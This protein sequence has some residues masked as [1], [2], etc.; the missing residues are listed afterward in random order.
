MKQNKNKEK[1]NRYLEA[2][3]N[4]KVLNISATRRDTASVR[5]GGFKEE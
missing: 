4:A 3:T 5:C 1:K 2:Y